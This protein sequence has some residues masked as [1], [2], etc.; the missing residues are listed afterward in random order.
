VTELTFTADDNLTRFLQK[1]RSFP[2]LPAAEERELA[3]RWRDSGDQDALQQLVSS[4][5]RLVVK[6]AMDNRGYGLPVADL[7]SEGHVGLMQAIMKFD[8][9]RGFR[10]STYARWWIRAAMQEYILRSWSLV[11]MGTTAAQKKLFFN[12]RKSKSRLQ[13][14]DEGDLDPEATGT[15]ADE[16]GVT[17]DEVLQMNRRMSSQDHSL[18]ANVGEQEV[19]WQ[20]L[21][22]DEA[23]DPEARLGALEELQLRRAYLRTAL[24]ALKPRE[25]HI[26]IERRLRD[27]PLTLETLSQQYGISRERV[28]QIEVRAYEKVREAMKREDLEVPQNPMPEATVCRTLLDAA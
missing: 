1:T 20:D 3:R 12:L 6:M 4:H 27:D 9:E 15:I 2:L 21:L 25:R 13:L 19:E 17:E 10:L 18:N 5:L 24:G 7:I 16:L 22:E 14:F 28:R 26:L 8:P 11:K 23:E